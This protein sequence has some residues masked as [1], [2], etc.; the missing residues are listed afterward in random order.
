MLVKK[1]YTVQNV[2]QR[3]MMMQR[4]ALNAMSRW[5]VAHALNVNGDVKKVNAS[6]YP[7]VDQLQ[8]WFSVS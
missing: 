4:F 6:G 3:M 2:A 5:L 7:T 8:V 1:W